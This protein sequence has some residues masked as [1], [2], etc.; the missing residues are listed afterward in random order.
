MKCRMCAWAK[1]TLVGVQIYSDRVWSRRKEI[2]E[3][4]YEE[5]RWHPYIA[6]KKR[7]CNSP[8][9][10]RHDKYKRNGTPNA[11]YCRS[12]LNAE[13]SIR[14][15]GPA[16]NLFCRDARKR[17]LRQTVG[18]AGFVRLCQ[19]QSCHYC[20]APIAREK[21]PRGNKPKSHASFI[22]RVDPRKGYVRG[23]CVPCCS[24]CNFAKN[25]Y[26]TGLEMQ[27][28]GALRKG[29]ADALRT[30]CE[31][32]NFEKNAL[33]AMQQFDA[34]WKRKMHKIKTPFLLDARKRWNAKK[35]ALNERRKSALI[36]SL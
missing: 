1:G 29:N 11:G 24:P 22:D 13:I 31:G 18:Y 33:A 8:V 26:L 25:S 20:E 23:N 34:I 35:K 7:G 16:Y 21:G 9:K 19:M 30:L 12:H 17:G 2:V 15:Y 6:C 5:C 28:V 27:V 36:A 3:F 4:R 14:A 10:M 32:F